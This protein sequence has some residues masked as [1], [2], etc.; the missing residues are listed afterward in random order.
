MNATSVKRA[1]GLAAAAASTSGAMML[2]PA[3]ANAATAHPAQMQTVSNVSRA[4]CGWGG[5]GWGGCGVGGLGVGGLG[6]GGLGVGGLGV[7]GLGVGGLG[8]GGIFP[9]FFFHHHFLFHHHFHHC[10]PLWG[11]CGGGCGVW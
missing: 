10:F 8:L 3:V 1:I 2:T 7:G 6:V 5:C 9:F 11:G 4:S